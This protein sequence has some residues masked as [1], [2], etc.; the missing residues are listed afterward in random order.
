M[1]FSGYF[2]QDKLLEVELFG[3]KGLC[4]PCYFSVTVIECPER[5]NLEEERVN[6]GLYLDSVKG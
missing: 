2:S 4:L 5:S 3:Y 1:R 6:F